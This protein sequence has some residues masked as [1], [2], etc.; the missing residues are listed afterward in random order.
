LVGS[1]ID[2]LIL[3]S[4]EPIDKVSATACPFC[5]D[6]EA[7]LRSSKHESTRAFLDAGKEPEKEPFGSIRKFRQHLGRHQEQLALF[8]LPRHDD[9]DVGDDSTGEDE[10]DPTD[11][12]FQE[13]PALPKHATPRHPNSLLSQKDSQAMGSVVMDDDGNHQPNNPTPQ[14]DQDSQLNHRLNALVWEDATEPTHDEVSFGNERANPR[15]GDGETPVG[16]EAIEFE[17]EID[18]DE[19]RYCYCD[20][21]S[22]GEMIGCDAEGCLK[23]WFHLGCVG[24]KT[25]PKGNEKWY[26]DDCKTRLAEDEVGLLASQLRDIETK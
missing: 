8:A 19:P 1:E 7:D 20:G 3:R 9:Q 15:T 21:V 16:D 6:W 18:E 11:N 25:P 5:D 14:E 2:A 4:E 22:Y 23:E 10:D 24:L 12:D 26:C 13:G 17:E